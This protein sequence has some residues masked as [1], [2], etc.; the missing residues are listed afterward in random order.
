MVN[1]GEVNGV[2]AHASRYLLTDVLRGELGFRG[3]V[4]SD[5]K[6]VE[7]LHS[8]HHV[9]ATEA[10]AVQLAVN[11][12]LDMSMVPNDF[13]FFPLLK[14]LVQK[15]KISE[16][17]I[18]ESVRN[19]LKVKAELGLFKNPYAEPEAAK[20]FGKPEYHQIALKAAEEALTLLKNENGALPLSKDGKVLVVGPTANALAPLNGCWSYTWQGTDERWYPKD[21]PTVVEAIRQK[22]GATNVLFHQGV[23]FFGKPV[24]IEAAV[25]DAGQASAVVLC[26]G[27][28]AYAETSGNINDLDLPAGQQNLAKQLYATGKPVILVLIEGR[29]RIIRE[30]VPGSKGI[31]MAYLPGSEGASAI[32]N[33]LFGDANPS[34]KL[35]FTYNRYANNFLTYDRVYTD[36]R[37]EKSDDEPQ[38]EFGSGLCYT[39]FEFKNLKL[40]SRVLK[41]DGQLTASVDVS[42]TGSREGKKTIELFTH[43]FYASVAPAAKRLRA[44]AKI[45]LQPG[46]SKTVSFNLTALDL[47]FVN[48]DSRLVTEPGHFELMIENLKTEFD[49]EL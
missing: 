35:P 5:W 1:S 46:E 40:S 24:D 15:G 8:W 9:A 17:R 30:I 22:I 26:L 18:D 25:A 16:A 12:G 48:A 34:G 47:A 3:F 28:N 13:S 10:D 14:Q 41:G 45:D 27:E 11:A 20:N 43:E 6:D 29:G 21:E 4:V 44:I 32:A 49:Y 39:T 42:N 2:P 33:V 31:L 36:G 23:D 38:F 19:I 37:T 7:N